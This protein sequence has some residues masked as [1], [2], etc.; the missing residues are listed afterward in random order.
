MHRMWLHC[1]I[2][3]LI[4]YCDPTQNSSDPTILHRSNLSHLSK[5]AHLENIVEPHLFVSQRYYTFVGVDINS[6]LQMLQKDGR[7]GFNTVVVD[8][9]DV[10]TDSYHRPELRLAP[11]AQS[12]VPSGFVDGRQDAN[13]GCS[14]PLR[15]PPLE[16]FSREIFLCCVS[17]F[18]DWK[19]VE[20]SGCG[21]VFCLPFL[22]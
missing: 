11:S 22:L 3:G 20:H 1:L 12:A 15:Q 4:V 5:Y 8:L 6:D 7:S 14:K 10:A 2:V 21:K 18:R 13:L 16:S 19:G 17:V 9:K